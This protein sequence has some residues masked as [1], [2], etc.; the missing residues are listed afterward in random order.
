MNP[1]GQLQERVDTPAVAG[2]AN[3]VRVECDD[4]VHVVLAQG[5]ATLGHLE[6]DQM[7]GHVVG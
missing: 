5:T 7:H 2:K 1:S 3:D 6:V 4:L